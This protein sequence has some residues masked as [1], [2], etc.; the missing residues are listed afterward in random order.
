MSLE[1]ENDIFKK[2]I[3]I[4]KSQKPIRNVKLN[5]SYLKIIGYIEDKKYKVVSQNNL[6]KQACLY[7]VTKYKNKK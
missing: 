4:L 5:K 6:T 2:V 3:S 1:K 7:I